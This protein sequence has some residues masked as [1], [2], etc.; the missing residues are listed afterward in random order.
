MDFNL[1]EEQSMLITTIREMGEK[2]NFR[3]LAME[4]DAT[5]EFPF[6]L[7]PMYS[8][9]GLL[10]L[11][12]SEE[13]G[14]GGQSALTAVLAIEELAKYSPM[15]AGPVFESNVG[16]IRVV[17]MFG[18]PEQKEL[19]VRGVCAGD[20]SV[21]VCMTEPEAGSDLTSL[22]TTLTADGGDYVL[23]GRKIFITGG[24]HASHYL[25]YARYGDIMGYKGIGAVLVE[26]DTPGFTFGEQ[27]QFMGLRGMPSCDLIFEDV[28]VP[29]EN[30][31]LKAGEFKNLM[32]T[33]DIERC[34]NAAMCLGV[35][36]GACEEARTY[37]TQREAFGRPICEFQDIQFRVVDMATRLEAARLLVYRAATG[38]GR[39][40][41]SMYEASMAKLFANEM[42]IDVT[43]SAALVFGGYGYSKQMPVER[44]VRDGRAWCV[45]GGTVQMLRVTVASVLF[46]RRFD[47]RKG[48]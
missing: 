13:Y 5:G 15:I 37:A 43:N 7:L 24:G 8:E 26:K 36:A 10:G 28:R 17:D 40:L 32:L 33:F 39:G 44:M 18:T 14:G 25:V 41:P 46:G 47:Q 21:S 12:L 16:P 20:N 3:E 22:S 1:T 48:K 19:L 30:V 27:E 42:V 6:Q 34:G 4:V 35:A 45:A 2:E 31:V 29:K 38:A 9:M 23:N 11:T